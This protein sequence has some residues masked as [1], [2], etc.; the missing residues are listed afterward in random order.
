MTS[1]TAHGV[2]ETFNAIAI[3]VQFNCA[4][5]FPVLVPSIAL[6]YKQVLSLHGSGTKA[7]QFE[8][9]GSIAV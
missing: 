4:T 2:Q 9:T 1:S 3:I 7:G 8:G 6:A 5:P